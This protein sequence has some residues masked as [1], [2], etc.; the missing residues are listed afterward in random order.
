VSVT[1]S[2]VPLPT[3]INRPATIEAEPW[4]LIDAGQEPFWK[5]IIR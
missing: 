1:K 2:V 5:A 4:A 3:G